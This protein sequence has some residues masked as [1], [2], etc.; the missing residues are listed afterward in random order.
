LL[1]AGEL[2]L[3]QRPSVAVIGSRNSDEAGRA[4]AGQ[5]GG[6]PAAANLAVVSG[7]ARGTDRL[8][9]EGVLAADGAAIGAVA[10]SWEATIRKSDVRESLLD[11]R[12]ALFTPYAPTAGSSVG[13]AMGRNKIS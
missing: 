5:I 3:L 6:K 2:E 1:G 7:G 9:M 8:A 12:L 4:F 13:L 10:D 11:G